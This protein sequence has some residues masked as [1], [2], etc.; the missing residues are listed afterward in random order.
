VEIRAATVQAVEQ[1]QAVLRQ[2]A[3]G[4]AG[5]GGGRAGAPPC[6]VQLDWWLWG[7]GEAQ[8]DAEGAPPHHRTLTMYY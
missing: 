7:V 5:G 1:L 3:A 8:R 6:S 2:R 4:A